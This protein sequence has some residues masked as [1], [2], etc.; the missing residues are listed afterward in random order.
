M[1]HWFRLTAGE[2][3]RLLIKQFID[4]S[5]ARKPETLVPSWPNHRGPTK[6]KRSRA[7]A[8]PMV[9]TGN[10]CRFRDSS[11]LCTVDAMT[12]ST[13]STCR[14][15]RL[16]LALRVGRTA[17]WEWDLSTGHVL[18]SEAANEL[19][20][21]SSGPA[22]EFQ[23]RIH[24][25][26]RERHRTALKTAVE[27]GSPYDAELRFLKADGSTIWIHDQAQLYTGPQGQRLLIGTVA[28]ISARKAAEEEL[29]RSEERLKDFAEIGSDWFWEMDADHRYVMATG[30]LA[31]ADVIGRTRWDLAGAD[32]TSPEWKEHISLHQ[33]RLPFRHFE[34]K[35]RLNGQTYHLSTSGRPVFD[36]GGIFQGYRGVTADITA[37]TKAEHLA[38][39]K[40]AVLEATLE[41]MNQGLMVLDEEGR[42]ALFNQRVLDLLDLPS[43]L[44]SARPRLEEVRDYLERRGESTPPECAFLQMGQGQDFLSDPPVYER[45]R[46]N[47]TII[48][49]RSAQLPSGGAVRTYTDTTARRHPEA[50]L[51]ESAERLSLATKATADAIWDWNLDQ[52]LVCRNEAI[53]T[54]FG[55]P[56]EA[57]EPTLNPHCGGGRTD[58]IPRTGKGS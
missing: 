47:G 34:H 45:T 21:L 8:F 10:L 58:S 3:H 51:R 55:Y 2:A 5:R 48:E 35:V 54:L 30:R 22:T 23:E 17:T 18:R 40:A 20:G 37:R 13:G 36:E 12:H 53:Q 44:L 46:Q 16:R 57:V 43:G 26:D 52:D 7:I 15:E 33:A 38:A 14:E 9:S 11:T 19:L 56:P 50:E 27:N 24:P 25:D 39:E 31:V 32:P 28:G 41:N 42:V 4:R 29:R 1:E 49:V 6:E